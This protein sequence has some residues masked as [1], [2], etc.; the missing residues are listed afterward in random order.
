MGGG[1]RGSGAIAHSPTAFRCGGARISSGSVFF[2]L[3]FFKFQ[4][5]FNKTDPVH[6]RSNNKIHSTKIC[7]FLIWPLENG[8]SGCTACKN[9]P[10]AGGCAPRPLLCQARF[11]RLNKCNPLTLP[12]SFSPNPHKH[13]LSIKS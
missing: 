9:A 4:A 1:R 5:S 7:N 11:A 3:K 12:C 8:V 6:S 10:A 13:I 2:R